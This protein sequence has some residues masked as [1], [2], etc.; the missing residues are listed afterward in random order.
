GSRQGYFKVLGPAEGED[1]GRG[2]AVRGAKQRALLAM[3]LLN[4]NE[5]IS[6]YGL[7]DEL[8]GERAPET[9]AHRL[10]EHVSRLRKLL[11]RNGETPVVTR[12][13]G[14]LLR[15]SDNDLDVAQFERL[16][17]RGRSALRDAQPEQAATLLRE[18]LALWRGRPLEDVDLDSVAWPEIRRLDERRAVAYEKLIDAELA[19][20]RHAE[21]VDELEALVSREPLRERLRVQQMLALYRS[22]RQAD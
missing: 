6:R 16:V 13:S 7:I 15:V 5:L 8:W 14:Y 12:P 17:T 22:G 18:A 1:D 10:E 19:Q 21:V 2:V 20:G 3:L 11:H 4:A 9:A